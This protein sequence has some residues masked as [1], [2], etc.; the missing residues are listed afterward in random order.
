MACAPGATSTAI[1][2][3]CRLHCPGGA[4]RLD[5]CRSLALVGTD[6]SE[7]VG[8][9]RALVMRGAWPR[10][11]FGPS[12]RDLVLLANAGLVGE[13]DLYVFRIDALFARDF[14]QTGWEA[15]LKSSI[16]PS[17]CA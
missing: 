7:D 2:D 8:G 17:A 3:R 16:A 15:L 9:G 10:A 4:A 11:S 6:R 1:S 14:V 13:P 12:A 5:Q